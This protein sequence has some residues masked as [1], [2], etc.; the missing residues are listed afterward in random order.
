MQLKEWI[1]VL[2]SLMSVTG[3]EDYDAQKIRSL[4]DGIFD[5]YRI[6]AVKNQILIKRCGR[7]NAPRILVDTHFDEIGMYV[8]DVKAGGFLTVTNVGGLD[9]RIL[10]GADVVIYGEQ[11]ILGVIAA[12]PPHLA[13]EKNKEKLRKSIGSTLCLS[14][15]RYSGKCSW[16]YINGRG[17]YHRSERKKTG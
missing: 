1:K 5:E 14:D 7:P 15:D 11:P 10:E 16:E 8:T 2:S 17:Y 4:T 13:D 12:F 9:T 6:D 3:F